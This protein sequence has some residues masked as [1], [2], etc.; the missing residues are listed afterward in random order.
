MA[1]L[2]LHKQGVQLGGCLIIC[3]KHP[4]CEANTSQD[5]QFSTNSSQL[6]SVKGSRPSLMHVCVEA[7]SLQWLN[8]KHYRHH[9]QLTLFSVCLLFPLVGSGSVCFIWTSWPFVFLLSLYVHLHVVPLGDWR[10]HPDCALI[11][12]KNMLHVLPSAGLFPADSYIWPLR[13]SLI[14][15]ICTELFN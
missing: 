10:L 3:C 8:R 2:G 7:C 12:W 1:P 9:L 14:F 11:P 13:L 5:M 6:R 15:L 4:L